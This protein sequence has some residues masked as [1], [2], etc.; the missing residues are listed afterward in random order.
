MAMTEQPYKTYSV[1][2]PF[3]GGTWCFEIKAQ[4]FQ[5]AEARLKAIGWGKVVGELAVTLPGWVPAWAISL[6]CR[7]LNW[8]GA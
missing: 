6:Y 8:K 2:Y 3:Q 4:S 7:W 5:E 1:E